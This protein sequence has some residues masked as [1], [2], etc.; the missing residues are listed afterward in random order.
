MK[1]LAICSAIVAGA[2]LGSAPVWAGD[3][4]EKKTTETTTSYSGTV[5][6]VNPSESHII[7]RSESAAPTTYTYNKKTTFVDDS[8][9]TVTY[10]EIKNKPVTVYYTKEGNDMI[11]S[12]VV[13]TRPTGG[14]IQKKTTTE[15]RE[16]R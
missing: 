9:N 15:E 6:E 11:V 1:N 8:G 2:L 13:V 3:V 7:I 16:V 5:S 4:M 14:M 12:R 10:S